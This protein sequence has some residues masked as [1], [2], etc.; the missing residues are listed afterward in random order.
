[1]IEQTHVLSHE[2]PT[3]VA[4]G[5]LQPSELL[6]LPYRKRMW[7]SYATNDDGARELHVFYSV[8]AAVKEITFDEERL[9]P[10]GEQLARQSSFVAETATTWG[11]GYEW[12]EIRELLE[13]LIDEG[14]VVRGSGVDE[15]RG[16]GL[17]P[18]RLPPSRCPAPRS[19]SAAE[20]EAITGEL[21]GR[22]VEVGYLEAIL[23]VYR[24]PHPVLD[25]DD[26]QVGEANVYPPALRLDRETEWRVCQ[27]PGSRYRDERPM[28]IT[29]LRAMI[30][31]WKPMMVTLL[32][33]RAELL[34]RLT[35]S[36]EDRW[37]VGDLHML[38]AVV[39]SLPAYLLMKGGGASPQ[40]PLHPV[41]SSL[42]RITDG[43]RM[44]THEMLFLSAERTRRPD[45]PTTAAELH[46]F[47]E[48]NR[49]LI[50]EYG[51]CAGPKAMIDE[52]L[53]TAC[54]GAP[55][56]GGDELVLPPQVQALLAELPAAVD[57]GL[58]GLQVWGLTRSVWLQMSLAYKALRAILTGAQGAQADA[59]RARLEADWRK[60]DIQRIAED[61]DRDVHLQVYEDCYEQPW[62]ALARPIGAPT[63]DAC[64]SACP[65]TSRHRVVCAHLQE[66]LLESLAEVSF[67]GQ[68]VEAAVSD[69][70]ELLTRY[71]RQEQTIL[72]SAT[73][74]QRALNE[75]LQR[76]HPTRAL[77]V[78]DLRVNYAM[79]GGHTAEFPYLF[80]SLEQ[81]LGIHVECTA[82]TIA[83]ARRF[84][85]TRAHR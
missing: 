83:V 17:A 32:A 71:L 73:A 35:R 70:A 74:L 27:Y 12:T 53:H 81:E 3:E 52:L 75:R 68:T 19:W 5:A 59:L 23:S 7:H 66:L 61:L 34:R 49:T 15:D 84:P 76:P 55:V 56:E 41:L 33:A 46:A 20:C 65:E 11:P 29:A 24:I 77:T 10:F 78:R 30:K 50:S 51:V 60:L 44:T 45:E 25:E 63:L 62:R 85:A 38:A 47:A 36:R 43:I 2:P 6:H 37:T 39:L 21:G 69:L 16:G 67:A 1:M 9:F 13:A 48:R 18:S 54:D 28:N 4:P 14:I 64:I 31:H 72:A 82:A 42:F 22:A 8:A 40:P 58:I 80:D 57:Y 79:Y 26:R